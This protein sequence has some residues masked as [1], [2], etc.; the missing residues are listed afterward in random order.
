VEVLR[1]GLDGFVAP[2]EAGGQEP[3]EREHHPP[4]GRGHAEEVEHHE[5]NGAGLMLGALGDGRDHF[6]TGQV[7]RRREGV[8]AGDVVA[9]EEAGH[10]GG[11][12]SQ[13]ATRQEDD[14]T[15]GV[16]EA[17]H[18]AQEGEHGEEARHQ[19]QDRPH[20]NPDARELLLL[21][22]EK[23]LVAGRAAVLLLDG[24]YS[25][26]VVQSFGHA[27]LLGAREAVSA[28]GSKFMFRKMLRWCFITLN[29]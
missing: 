6:E 15:L 1:V 20:A 10:V 22:S 16:A 12:H 23:H 24:A 14:G 28:I 26:G 5:D 29:R 7:G 9:L 19:A 2:L 11:R 17:V 25:Q 3:G 13:V 27:E 21:D 4:D 8:A 18:V